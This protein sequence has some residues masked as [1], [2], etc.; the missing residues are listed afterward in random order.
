MPDEK[1]YYDHEGNVVDMDAII[2]QWFQDHFPGSQEVA[3]FTPAWNLVL[4]AT[5]NLKARFKGV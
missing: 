3:G 1:K 2:E 5:V 4:A